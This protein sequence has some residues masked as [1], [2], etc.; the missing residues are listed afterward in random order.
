MVIS[1]SSSVTQFQLLTY[2]LIKEINSALWLKRILEK[3]VFST[4]IHK[5]I[6]FWT[7]F[8]TFIWSLF[9]WSIIFFFFLSKSRNSKSW[10]LHILNCLFLTKHTLNKRFPSPTYDPFSF[11]SKISGWNMLKLM[12]L[13]LKHFWSDIYVSKVS[14]LSL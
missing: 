9:I 1:V 3:Q 11:Y 2:G 8:W 4:A 14:I 5:I 6:F 12:P 10:K 7:F 13:K